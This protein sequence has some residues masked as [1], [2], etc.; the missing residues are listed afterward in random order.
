MERKKKKGKSVH[1][2][3]GVETV[4]VLKRKRKEQKMKVL[5]AKKRSRKKKVKDNFQ[6][7]Y[8]M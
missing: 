8:K 4:E 2:E 5:E 1:A 6:G 3:Q 7:K